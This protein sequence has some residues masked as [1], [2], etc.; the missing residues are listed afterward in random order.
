MVYIGLI[1]M[2]NYGGAECAESVHMYSVARTRVQRKNH[3]TA[4]LQAN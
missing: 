2:H 4:E 3:M 1:I